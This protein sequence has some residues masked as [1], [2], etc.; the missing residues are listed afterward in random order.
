[1]SVYKADA[2][3]IEGILVVINRS[4]SEAYRKIIPRKY[5]REPVLSKD[6]LMEDFGR[7]TFYAYK[8]EENTVGVAALRVVSDEV[9]A[10]TL[11]IRTP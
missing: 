2:K 8:V 1:V 7:M 10:N 3:D 4:N 6:A 9:G 11:G 5:F